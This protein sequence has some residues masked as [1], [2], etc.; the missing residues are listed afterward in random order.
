MRKRF[1]KK[2]STGKSGEKARD[3]YAIDQSIIERGAEEILETLGNMNVLDVQDAF[4]A[5]IYTGSQ[6]CSAL[7]GVFGI[8]LD[9]KQYLPKM[10]NRTLINI[11]G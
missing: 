11:S 4:Y 7:N 3:H 8:G 5:S 1:I 2:T 6:L 9:K 10:L